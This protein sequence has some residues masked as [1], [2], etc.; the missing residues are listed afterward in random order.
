M[1]VQKRA[2]Y[3][4]SPRRLSGNAAI[5]FLTTICCAFSILRTSCCGMFFIFSILGQPPRANQ[6]R[7]NLNQVVYWIWSAKNGDWNFVATQWYA[8]IPRL[9]HPLCNPH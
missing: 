2:T 5:E 1:K 6:K 4:A 9:H 7:L 3:S 8:N